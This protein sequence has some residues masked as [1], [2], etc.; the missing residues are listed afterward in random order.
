MDEHRKIFLNFAADKIGT[1]NFLKFGK[2]DLLPKNTAIE[3]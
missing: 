2:F 1:T 3:K